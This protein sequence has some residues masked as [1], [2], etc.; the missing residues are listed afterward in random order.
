MTALEALGG[1][2]AVAIRGRVAGDLQDQLALH[3]VDTVAAW[4]AAAPTTE[5]RRLVSFRDELR[6]A[7]SDVALAIVINCARARLSEVDDIHLAAMITPGSIVVP[8]ALSIAASL[9]STDATAL[10]EAMVA[11]YEA[12]AR[13]GLAVDGPSILYR[14]IWPSYFAAGFAVAAVAA[15][16]LNLTEQQ[17]AHALA[18][19]LTLA[20]PGVAGHN[21]PTTS[22]WL[23]A[24]ASARNGLLAARAAQAGFTSD[25]GMLDG[26]FLGGVYDIVPDLKALTAGL[27][28]HFALRDV[29]FKPWCGARQTMAATQAFK[30]IIAGGVAADSIS[31]IEVAVPPPFLR[32]V[33]HGIDDDDRLSRLTSVPYQLAIALLDPGAAFDIG[34][35]EKVSAEV[36]A[37]MAKIKIAADDSLLQGFPAVWPARVTVH[38]G[39]VR[40][41][42]Q[43]THIPGDPA[44]PF[45]ERDVSEKFH[46]VADR[47]A[48]AAC[49]D[50]L[51]ETTRR[52]LDGSATAAHL[53]GEIE[54]V[55]AVG[56]E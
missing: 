48:G 45:H 14:G 35:T 27:G 52:V 12:M 46:R 4:L 19:A 51:I 41:E 33:D 1:F 50:R 21:T 8:A 28:D 26:K 9:P 23:A 10:R 11:G 39:G 55:C 15:R 17:A 25:L 40:Q 2:V 16:L 6:P 36:L 22:R 29:S 34:Q 47:L 18:L 31:S 43:V 3:V 13:L 42:R 30:E 38:A 44:R 53:I 49:V 32:M 54:Q 24:G 5:A 20:P 37:L 56:R 7:S